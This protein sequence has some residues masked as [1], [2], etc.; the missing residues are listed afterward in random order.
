VNKIIPRRC[1]LLLFWSNYAVAGQEQNLGSHGNGKSYRY[2]AVK[3]DKV[4]TFYRVYGAGHTQA[5]MAVSGREEI[6]RK[7]A[8]A[9]RGKYEAG[10]KA[11]NDS[12]DHARGK[13]THGGPCL[14]D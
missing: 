10:R 9:P 12:R 8:I 14:Y 6:K 3:P 5:R 11:L 2:P 7:W 4:G 1:F 13:K